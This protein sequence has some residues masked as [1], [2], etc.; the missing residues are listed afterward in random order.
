M[1]KIDEIKHIL[2]A[3][4]STNI[5]LHEAANEILILFGVSNNEVAVCCE[6]GKS[7]WITVNGHKGCNTEG[8]PAAN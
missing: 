8:C 4:K 3:Y 2:I 6:C 1:E 7:N 5:G